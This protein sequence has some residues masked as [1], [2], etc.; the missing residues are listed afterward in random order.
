MQSVAWQS[1]ASETCNQSQ[2]QLT[3]S[4]PAQHTL[5][6]CGWTCGP[7]VALWMTGLQ[8]ALLIIMYRCCSSDDGDDGR[9]A[10]AAWWGMRN[11]LHALGGPLWMTGVEFASPIIMY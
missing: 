8:F 10:S 2:G 11:A 9:C 4:R 1:N 3:P 7:V 6:C 5:T